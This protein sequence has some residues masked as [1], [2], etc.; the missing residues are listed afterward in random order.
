MTNQWI[1]NFCITRAHQICLVSRSF[2]FYGVSRTFDIDIKCIGAT[3]N[4]GGP[5]FLLLV[6]LCKLISGPY[7]FKPV[8]ADLNDFSNWFGSH[9][10]LY[11]S[12]KER[13]G[14]G[15]YFMNLIIL[16]WNMYSNRIKFWTF[17]LLD[18]AS[19]DRFFIIPPTNI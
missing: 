8:W 18:I 7:F 15:N 4:N 10:S 1:H 3:R 11:F 17:L 19:Y 6:L 13:L 5:T 14:S 2:C 9:P 16:H 12:Q